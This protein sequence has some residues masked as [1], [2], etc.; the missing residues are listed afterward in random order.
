MEERQ[1]YS[2]DLK[3]LEEANMRLM[4]DNEGLRK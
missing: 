3:R 4:L 1:Q 2:A